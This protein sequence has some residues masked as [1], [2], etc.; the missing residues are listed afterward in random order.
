[1]NRQTDEARGDRACGQRPGASSSGSWSWASWSWASWGRVSALVGCLVGGLSGC[2]AEVDESDE[3]DVPLE[4]GTE[5]EAFAP[6][7]DPGAEPTQ[8]SR[9]DETA[10]PQPDPWH[11]E[12]ELR[13]LPADPESEPQPDP[14]HLGQA[15]EPNDRD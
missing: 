1:V 5:V 4:D 3:L 10:D 13:V 9:G 8:S 11:H 6:D 7:V 2:V 12:V 14:W 15:H